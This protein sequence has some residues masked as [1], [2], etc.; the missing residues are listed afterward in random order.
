VQPSG[1]R[2]WRGRT[3]GRRGWEGAQIFRGRMEAA[4]LA[5]ASF[6]NANWWGT[7]IR[8]SSAHFAD[9]RTDR[10]LTQAQL[11]GVIGN[12]WTLLPN[13]PNEDGKPYYVWSCWIE[14]PPEIDAI[15]ALAAGLVAD[16]EERES[17]RREYVCERNERRKTGTPLALDAP[18]PDGHPLAARERR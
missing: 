5:G 1:R 6:R 12:E 8:A 10:T 16:D 9:L 4:A 2:E 15:A 17:L 13:R 11:E 18:Y 7:S 3:C 14:P